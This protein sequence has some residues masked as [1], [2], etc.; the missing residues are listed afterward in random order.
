MALWR[1][2]LKK[3][4]A[5][6]VNMEN[7]I[8]VISFE[9]QTS[10][11]TLDEYRK[12][13]PS[14]LITSLEQTGFYVTS[15]ERQ[16][17]ILK[18]VGR[19]GVEF[20][21]SDLG[22]E[23]CRKDGVRSLVTGTIYRA[24]ETFITDVKVLDVRTK[25]LLRTAKAQGSGSNSI[26]SSQVDDLSRQ[27]AAGLGVAKE[28]IDASLKPVSEF[29]TTSEEAYRHYLKAREYFDHGQYPE[30][31]ECY[32]KA[33]EIDPEFASAYYGLGATYF[34]EFQRQAAYPFLEKAH[35]L[36]HRATEKNRYLIE[37]DYAGYMPNR[38]EERYA[39]LIK[40]FVAKYPKE[41]EAHAKL[42]DL[43][44]QESNSD[45]AIEELRIAMALDPT[46]T[47]FMWGLGYIHLRRKEYTKAVE[48]FEKYALAEPE[49][50]NAFDSLAEGYFRMGRVAEAKATWSKLLEK[51]PHLAVRFDGL[52][53]VCA[54]EENYGEAVRRQ[55]R[56]LEVCAP[57]E[58]P[59]IYAQRGF[60]R[61]WA[62]DLNG[63]L[64]DLQRADESAEALKTKGW[65]IA[66]RLRSWI[67][68]DQ[69]QLDLSR[70]S[71]EEFL[72]L[73]HKERP[74]R[75]VFYDAQYYDLLCRVE[76]E[77]GKL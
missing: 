75:S 1:I 51:W 73:A 54:L 9:N 77:E 55:D 42:A 29:G 57:Q 8:A 66:R 52:Q 15:A 53:Y 67:Y 39:A 5:V 7:S 32:Q 44:M 4:D 63:A 50:A 62:G 28:K 70:K 13:I 61:G 3:G 60:Y 18:Q 46:Y 76:C 17:D 69:H 65:V 49:D 2:L 33:V 14:L 21:D 64:G 23:V 59:A 45:K 30:A 25:R 68:F 27:I 71:L 19:G 35:S 74:E 22:F 72:A 12:I 41:K 16:R 11:K 48:Y 20:I 47:G 10:D 6:S 31:R 36:S 43:Y 34:W 40:E 58:K 24:G 37:I 26:Y 38:N 56:T